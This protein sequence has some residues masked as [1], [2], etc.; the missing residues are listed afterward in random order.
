MAYENW[1]NKTHAYGCVCPRCRGGNHLID[2]L[3]S[4]SLSTA[5]RH[6]QALESDFSYEAETP[7]GSITLPGTF[8]GWQSEITLGELFGPS[9]GVPYGSKSPG[10]GP[11]HGLLYRIYQDKQRPL[12]IGMAYRD[13]IQCRVASHFKDMMT[14]AGQPVVP[15]T[16]T[17]LC[18]LTKTPPSAN[19]RTSEIAKLRA[20]TA[21]AG[22]NPIIKVQHAWVKPKGVP[23]DPK[24]LHAFESA[25]QVLER[26]HS[27]VGSARTFETDW[28]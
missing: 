26:P 9:P 3:A 8:K 7:A 2:R 13:S 1:P 22:L 21:A 28:F 27:Y 25:L 24:L 14:K 5:L 19:I 16:I 4:R 11:G 17:K 20:L 15:Q 23:L 10:P 6:A 12:Y 18:K